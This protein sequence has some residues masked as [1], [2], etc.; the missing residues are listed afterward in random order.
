MSEGDGRIESDLLKVHYLA[1]TSHT[2]FAVSTFSTI[3]LR[4]YTIQYIFAL[5]MQENFSNISN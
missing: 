5:H 4:I 3:E 2:S 1:G